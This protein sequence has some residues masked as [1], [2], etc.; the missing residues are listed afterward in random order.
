MYTIH[1]NRR[2]HQVQEPHNTQE[3]ILDI[4]G[5]LKQIGKWTL[6]GFRQQQS[7]IELY[8]RLTRKNMN[9]ISER[10]LGKKFQTTYEDVCMQ[11]EKLEKEYERGIADHKLWANVMHTLAK[12]LE[13][14][15]HLV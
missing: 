5:N 4:S 3:I 2:P 15:A 13:N 11:Y 9:T 7:N 10:Q 12:S 6:K 14:T 1:I 8:L